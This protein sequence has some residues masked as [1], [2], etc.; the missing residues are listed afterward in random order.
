MAMNAGANYKFGK[1]VS[2]F[3]LVLCLSSSPLLLPENLN[4][5]AF[6]QESGEK[7]EVNKKRP[8]T[9]KKSQ[10]LGKKVYEIIT[11]ANE[12]VDADQ[13]SAA[14]IELDK[15]KS[16]ENLTTYETAQIYSFYGYLYFNAE[17]YREAINS[18]NKVLQQPDLPP[19]VLQQSIRTLAQLSFVTE[20]YDAAIRYANQYLNDGGPDADMYV[21][22]GT[23][24][25][26]K[27]QYAEIIPPDLA[28]A[29]LEQI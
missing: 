25:Y 20:D 4:G 26:Q 6:A 15:T 22:L 13:T 11:K 12:L 19:A 9:G 27:D 16:M 2:I 18:Y 5:Y 24:Y 23:A 8:R 3:A 28:G 29:I 14:L 17:R 7:K 1:A 21:V 10:A